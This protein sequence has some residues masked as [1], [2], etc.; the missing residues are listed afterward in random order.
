TDTFDN[1]RWDYFYS[2]V[3]S[4]GKRS[5]RQ[6]RLSFDKEDLLQ[7]VSGDFQLTDTDPTAE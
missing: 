2:K 3:D 5:E 7:S 6:L 1:S 4:E